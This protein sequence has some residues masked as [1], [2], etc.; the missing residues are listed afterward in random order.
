MV[1][2][3]HHTGQYDVGDRVMLMQSRGLHLE[4]ILENQSIEVVIDLHRD[5]G[6]QYKADRTK[7]IVRMAQVIFLIG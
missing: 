7:L 3:I 5:V 6:E 2:V 1:S 4:Q